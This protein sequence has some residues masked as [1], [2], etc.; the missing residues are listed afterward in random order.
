MPAFTQPI[1][2]VPIASGLNQ[3]LAIE[4]AGDGTGDLY[5]VEQAGRILMVSNGS[6]QPQ[7]FLDI[8]DRVGCCMERG[9]LGLAFHPDFANNGE[10]FVNYTNNNFD[11]V[12]ARFT[13]NG[14]GTTDADTEEILLTI[15]QPFSNHNGGQLAF[16]P[17]GFLYIGTGDGGSGGDPQNNAQNPQSLLGKMLRIDVDGGNPYAIPEDNPFALT[18]FELDEIWATGLRNPFRFSFDAVTGDLYIADVGQDLVEE[19]HVHRANTPAGENFGWRLMEGSRCFN[20]D[21]DCND[22][23]LTLPAFEYL[24]SQGR[25]S[26]TGG[27]VYRGSAVPALSGAY[28]YGDFCSGEIFRADFAGDAWT[29][30]VILETGFSISSFGQDEDAELYVADLG[31]TVYKLEQPITISPGSGS[32]L[33]TQAVDLSFILRKTGVTITGL[34]VQLNGINISTPVGNCLREGQL[35]DGGLSLRCPGIPLRLLPEGVHTL[36]VIA[37]LSDG[38]SVSDT[39]RWEILENSEP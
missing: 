35:A 21:T 1:I 32:Y 38:E 28:I 17:D 6:V 13:A 18:D 20:P 4:H 36:A 26:I 31:G 14:N 9:L 39:V 7:A 22:G 8:R 24:H 10:Y 27:Y 16:G 30:E 34:E 23:S 29:Q 25:C 12:I 33:T 5:I 11:T 15:D 19:V 3:P 37:D 2:P